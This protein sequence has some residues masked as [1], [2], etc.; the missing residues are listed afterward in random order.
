MS[1]P[2]VLYLA[3]GILA[4]AL[5]FGSGIGMAFDPAPRGRGARG[6]FG[7][8]LMTA[9]VFVFLLVYLMVI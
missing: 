2:A 5:L 1:D 4:A 6:I 9:G 7:A 8:G 3:V